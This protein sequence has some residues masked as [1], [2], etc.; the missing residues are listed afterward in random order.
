MGPLVFAAVMFVLLWVLFIRPQQR[1]LRAH[2]ALVRRLQ[3]GDEV[4]TGSGLFGTILELDDEVVRLEVA[5]DTVVK[6]ARG[7]VARRLVE[8][9]PA[10]PAAAAELELDRQ[11]VADAGA[12]PDPAASE[13]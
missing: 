11:P 1:R 9:E 12:D 7:S 8:D 13:T 5:P 3:A 10:T 2:D 6:V 4:M